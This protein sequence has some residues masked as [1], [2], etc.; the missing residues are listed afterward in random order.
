MTFYILNN[1]LI[2]NVGR[3]I[4]GKYGVQMNI[5]RLATDITEMYSHLETDDS[6]IP[7]FGFIFNR[8]F[9]SSL[10]FYN[11]MMIFKSKLVIF[12]HN[13]NNTPGIILFL[14]FF[15]L[16]IIVFLVHLYI[17]FLN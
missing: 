11:L 2:P 8:V 6:C 15:Y 13:L 5:D 4:T 7:H 12:T 10:L 1:I 17:H 16:F 14:H 9:C 3:N